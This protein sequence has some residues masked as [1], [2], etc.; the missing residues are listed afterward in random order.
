M[1]NRVLCVKSTGKKTMYKGTK[2]EA[3]SVI[4][5]G[6]RRLLA[7]ARRK[8]SVFSCQFFMSLE[9]LHHMGPCLGSAAIH[10]RFTSSYKQNK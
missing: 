1:L 8:N 3:D 9:Y 5:V 4:Y 6:G 10:L 7:P 2:Y